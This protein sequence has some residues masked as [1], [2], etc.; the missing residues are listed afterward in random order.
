M[1]GV[2]RCRSGWCGG[3]LNNGRMPSSQA[4]ARIRQWFET[5]GRIRVRSRL[6]DTRAGRLW[7]HGSRFELMHRAM[8]FAALGFVTMIPLLIVVAALDPVNRSGFELWIVNG[9]GL[10]ESSADAAHELFSTPPRVI[11]TTSAFS[12]V[13]LALFGLTFASRVQTGYE[14]IW[15]LK[16]SPWHQ[17][18]R[19]L[20][21]LTALTAYLFAEIQS[22][23]VLREGAGPVALR[24]VLTFVFGVLFF[25]WGQHLLLAGRVSWWALLPGAV[26]TML[27][28]VGLRAFSSFVFAPLIVS[29]TGT[30]GAVGTLLIVQSWL[31][32]VGFVVFGGSL[33]GHHMHEWRTGVPRSG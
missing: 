10:D 14:Q 23:A 13:L 2:G 29:S 12:A 1:A 28:L 26:A 19:Q 8:G 18:W 24:T 7:H 25:W 6:R 22:E 17:V 30:Y 4:W 27:G 5:A 20:L 16:P 9:M 32:G 3:L 21:W 11:N 15:E 33:L 31:I